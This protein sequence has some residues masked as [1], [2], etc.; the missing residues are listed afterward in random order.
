MDK[1]TNHASSE[2]SF[3]CTGTY[4]QIWNVQN[5]HCLQQLEPTEDAEV[6]GIIPLVDR[7]III[8]V[9]WNRKII[10]Y[11]DSHPEVLCV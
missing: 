9:G 11:D 10:M 1:H 4:L 8:A 5:G 3:D 2:R 7:K 6:T